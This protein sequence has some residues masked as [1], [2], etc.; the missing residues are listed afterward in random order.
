[1]I[2]STE[3]GLIEATRGGALV[4]WSVFPDPATLPEQIPSPAQL[5]LKIIDPAG[6]ISGVGGVLIGSTSRPRAAASLWFSSNGDEAAARASPSS[7]APLR[8]R[9][10]A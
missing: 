1:R 9:A 2:H 8:P 7:R 10:P 3:D 5:R 4:R 6:N